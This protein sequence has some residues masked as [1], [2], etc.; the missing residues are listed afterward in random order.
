MTGK[1]CY[2]IQNHEIKHLDTNTHTLWQHTKCIQPTT[3]SSVQ[4]LATEI[5]TCRQ[6]P[7]RVFKAL[8]VVFGVHTERFKGPHQL[9]WTL[10]D[11]GEQI[12][13]SEL[14]QFS[15]LSALS[16]R[17]HLSRE[18]PS[19]GRVIKNIIVHLKLHHA[20]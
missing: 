14:A 13:Y 4:I 17:Y 1:L 7:K 20:C 19:L 9:M 5:T 2:I 16:K 15:F 8:H 3:A 11:D 12:V 10:Q 6:V 18:S